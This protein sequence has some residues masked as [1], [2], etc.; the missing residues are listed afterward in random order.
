VN[1]EGNLDTCGHARIEGSPNVFVGETTNTAQDRPLGSDR[2]ARNTKESNKGSGNASPSNVACRQNE[3][4]QSKKNADPEDPNKDGPQPNADPDD[5]NKPV[6]AKPGVTGEGQADSEQ[7]SRQRLLAQMEQDYANRDQWK[8]GKGS[9]AGNAAFQNL[10]YGNAANGTA[11]CAGYVNSNLKDAGAG[12]ASSLSSQS[13]TAFKPVPSGQAKPGDVLVFDH[14]TAL[15]KEVAPNGDIL[16]QGGN[17]GGGSGAVTQNWLRASN[18]YNYGGQSLQGIYNPHDKE[19]N[20]SHNL[21]VIPNGQQRPG[22]GSAQPGGTPGGKDCP[23]QTPQEQAA[24]EGKGTRPELGGDGRTPGDVAYPNPSSIL[25]GI[26][27]GGGL[28]GGGP[29]FPTNQGPYPAPPK[30]DPMKIASE[31]FDASMD[32]NESPPISP[33]NTCDRARELAKAATGKEFPSGTEVAAQVAT[34]QKLWWDE[35]MAANQYRYE[36]AVEA[37]R[38]AGITAFRPLSAESMTRIMAYQSGWGNS[39]C[40]SSAAYDK[41]NPIGIG[42][43]G[44]SFYEYPDKQL[45]WDATWK[46]IAFGTDGSLGRYLL[47]VD[48]PQETDFEIDY[49]YK[50]GLVNGQTPP[51]VLLIKPPQ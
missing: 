32:D 37:Y 41:N 10:G 45:G 23:P 38:Q 21:N 12:Y 7:A 31:V 27:G 24:G 17:Q 5:P 9:P 18:G 43:N 13:P 20:A 48:T 35:A 34:A 47:P 22:Y 39:R 2:A 36:A 19:W 46:F 16:L 11:W 49:I 40:V 15:V 42:W 33:L 44:S 26:L 8:G 29:T 28:F 50:Q 30:V 3:V 1:F 14:H 6:D 51:G 25:G 4:D